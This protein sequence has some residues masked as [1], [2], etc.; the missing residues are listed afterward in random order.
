MN[1][2]QSQGCGV[3]R[4]KCVSKD[5]WVIVFHSS[6]CFMINLVIS[7][8]LIINYIFHIGFCYLAFHV[9]RKINFLKIEKS[10]LVN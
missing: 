7:G 1:D 10:F 2:C 6:K 5:L 3:K 4:T 8:N 9:E